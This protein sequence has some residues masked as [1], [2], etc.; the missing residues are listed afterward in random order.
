M[1]NEADRG[2]RQRGQSVIRNGKVEG[3][4]IGQIAGMMERDDLSP[5]LADQLVTADPT[6]EEETAPQGSI[7]VTHD[8]ASGIKAL[9][10]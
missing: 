2:I 3:L 8:V 1:C 4:Q 7:A 10:T 9:D 5:P 6:P